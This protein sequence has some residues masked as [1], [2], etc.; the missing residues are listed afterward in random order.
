MRGLRIF[1]ITD[2]DNPKYLA[3]VQTCRGSHTHTVVQDPKDNK[4]IYVYISGTSG[5]RPSE[6]LPRCNDNPWD[7]NNS[8]FRIEVIKIPL[9]HPEQADVVS[10]PRDLRRSDNGVAN[11]LLSPRSPRC[12]AG[13][14]RGESHSRAVRSARVKL[15]PVQATAARFRALHRAGRFVGEAVQAST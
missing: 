14:H 9:A 13:R 10:S 5:I 4:N 6:E 8:K 2:I 3:N 1:D 11:G 7:P 12:V 15:A